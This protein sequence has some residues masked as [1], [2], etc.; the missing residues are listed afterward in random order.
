MG[1]KNGATTAEIYQKAKELGLEL[2]PAEV[3]PD[4]CLKYLDQP[5]NEWFLIAMKQI[6]DR[7][8]YPYVFSLERSADGLWL[9]TNWAEPDRRRDPEDGFV[10][11]LRK[12]E[13]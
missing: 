9:D 10:F 7:D 3:G 1:F 6:P 5:L 8:D 12:L 4:L 11:R 13:S 2:C